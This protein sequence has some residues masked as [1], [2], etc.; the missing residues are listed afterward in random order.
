MNILIKNI[1]SRLEIFESRIKNDAE[2][3]AKLQAAWEIG[4]DARE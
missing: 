4:R 1:I 3:L 2:R